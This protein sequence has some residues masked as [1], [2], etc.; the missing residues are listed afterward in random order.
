MFGECADASSGEGWDVFECGA[1]EYF[2]D[3]SVNYFDCD[4]DGFPGFGE[5]ME[6]FLGAKAR[7]ACS[8]ESTDS[9][10]MTLAIRAHPMYARLVEAYYEC[11]KIGA[12]GDAAV[13]LEREKDAMLYSVQVMSEEA[14]ESSAMALDVASC[15]LDEFMRDCTHELETYVKELHSLYED[16]KRCC[17]SLEN[18]AHKVKTDVVHVDSSRRGEAA[19][20]KRH[21]P[22]T[23]DELEAVSDD[24]DQ[25]LASE[26]QRR[27]H[28]ERLRQDLKR[29]YASSITM[30]KT[31]FMRKRK[32]G[33]LP[34]TSTDILKKWWSDNIVWP[35]PSEDDKQVLIE[36]TKLDATQVNNWFINFRKRHWIRLFERG[37]TP[38]NEKEAATALAKAFNGSL[39]KAKD[40]ARSL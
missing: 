7:E 36:M 5:D 25:I 23:E 2:C 37:C 3:P 1:S 8:S 35:Y 33:K 4:V 26:H 11:R 18:R 40:Y 27:N 31:E 20:S 24:F 13:A 14:Y 9:E 12:H 10:E 19:E 17:K 28:E 22:A 29:K 15:D 34:D 21:A 6:A 38:K 16:A 39:E 32:K 30:L